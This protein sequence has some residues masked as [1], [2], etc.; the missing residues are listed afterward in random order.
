[1]VLE[2]GYDLAAL[3]ASLVAA[4]EGLIGLP[5]DDAT[6][7]ELQAGSRHALELDRA[8]EAARGFWHL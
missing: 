2:G 6:A 3:E 5:A 4:L 1:M 7:A 8:L